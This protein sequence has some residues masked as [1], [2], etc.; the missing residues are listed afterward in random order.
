MGT[1]E[2]LVLGGLM[3]LLGQGARTVVGLK[4]MSD[5]AKA[6]DLNPNDLFESARLLSSLMLGFLVG[7]AAALA[8]YLSNDAIGT[9]G[10]H[11]LL[12]FV[13]SGYAGTDFLEGFISQYLPAGT[14]GSAAAKLKG[15]QAAQAA[16]AAELAKSTLS[17][18]LT[19]PAGTGAVAFPYDQAEAIVL[20]VLAEKGHPAVTDQTKLAD[21]GYSNDINVYKLYA[22][23]NQAII[24]K[25]YAMGSAV[26]ANWNKVGD[27]VSSVEH[28]PKILQS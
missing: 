3:G 26:V 24:P 2:F 1:L 22:A 16:Q 8:Y 13:A 9:P 4:A 12:G 23:M 21:I 14:T 19:A 17:A 15:Q 28:A 18:L 11:V 25:G 10:A 5:D 20:K 7:L 27:I 6:L